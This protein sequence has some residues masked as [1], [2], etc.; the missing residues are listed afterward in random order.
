MRI[1]FSSN[2]ERVDRLAGS[3]EGPDV[4]SMSLEPAGKHAVRVTSRPR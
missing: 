3:V 4:E 2:P 1:A